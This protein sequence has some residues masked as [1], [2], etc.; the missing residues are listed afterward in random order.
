MPR[1]LSRQSAVLIAGVCLVVG[2]TGAAVAVAPPLDRA[3]VKHVLLLSVDG[4]RE[5]DLASYTSTHPR[6]AMG[7]LGRRGDELHQG[8]DDVSI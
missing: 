5:S 4:L 8:A 6:S 3:P 7:G 1:R 2:G